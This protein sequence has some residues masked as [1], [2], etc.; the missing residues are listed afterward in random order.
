LDHYLKYNA[1]RLTKAAST[2]EDTAASP[3]N[4]GRN[5]NEPLSANDTSGQLNTQ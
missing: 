1:D 5:T 2:S 4:N 3:N